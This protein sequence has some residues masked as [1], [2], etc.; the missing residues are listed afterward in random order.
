MANEFNPDSF[1]PFFKARATNA[2]KNNE[3]L[4][5]ISIL[6][7][8][9]CYFESLDLWVDLISKQSYFDT[10][11]AD[12]ELLIRRFSKCNPRNRPPDAVFGPVFCRLIEVMQC[13][14]RVLVAVDNNDLQVQN[15]DISQKLRQFISSCHSLINAAFGR[16]IE[17]CNQEHDES[18]D[19]H[20]RQAAG[21]LE[22][23]VMI[24][25]PSLHGAEDRVAGRITHANP[26]PVF[27]SALSDGLQ[28]SRQQKDMVVEPSDLKVLLS[29]LGGVIFD[30]LLQAA[31]HRASFELLE[32]YQAFRRETSFDFLA[33]DTHQMQQVMQALLN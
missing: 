28:S 29:M 30:K 6:G 32:A 3:L 23:S 24:P 16:E 7:A 10:Q 33:L 26:P 2:K 11:Q 27:D 20:P 19:L 8:A 18:A 17:A 15:F 13:A 25:E 12:L 31:P 5:A 21:L 14:Q 4:R 1:V 22:A 9:G